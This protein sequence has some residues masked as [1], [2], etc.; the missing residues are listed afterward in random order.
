MTIVLGST[1]VYE[2]RDKLLTLGHASVE[3][4]QWRGQGF[5]VGG[6]CSGGLGA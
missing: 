6:G 2:Q 3:W 5:A 4:V 1:W